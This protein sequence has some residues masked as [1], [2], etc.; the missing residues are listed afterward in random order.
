VFRCGGDDPRQQQRV[1]DYVSDHFGYTRFAILRTPGVTAREHL[2]HWGRFARA[3]TASAGGAVVEIEYD[4]TT[5]DVSSMLRSLEQSGADV[6]LTWADASVSAGI[7]RA[8]RDRGLTPL[9]VGSSEIV[10][11][12]FVKLAGSDTGAVIALTACPHRRDPEAVAR[13]VEAYVSQNSPAQQERLPDADAY[14]AYHA[15]RHLLLAVNMAGPDRED[16]RRILA[17]MANVRLATL[18][19]GKWELLSLPDR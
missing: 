19:S 2:D 16:I 18:K 12:E 4:P 9:F 5:G 8:M 15:A 17:K 14:R 11:D 6:V 1:V 7:L 3:R 13:F 10:C